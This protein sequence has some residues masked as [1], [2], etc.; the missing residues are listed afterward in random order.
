MMGDEVLLVAPA[1]ADV[2]KSAIHEPSVKS[3]QRNETDSG[4][5]NDSGDPRGPGVVKGM[6]TKKR[7]SGPKVRSA[8]I[9][10]K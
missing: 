5:S 10:C 6:G 9:T 8:C 7:K 1:N 4:G 3:R 2:S